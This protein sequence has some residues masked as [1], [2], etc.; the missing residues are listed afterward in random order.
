MCVCVCVCVCVFRSIY[1]KK[2]LTVVEGDPKAP[3]SNLRVRKG[4]TTFPG[5]L[6]FTLDTYLVT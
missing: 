6:Y 1:I 5:L 3:F 2:I 4:A